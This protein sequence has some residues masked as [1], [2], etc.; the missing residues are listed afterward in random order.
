MAKNVNE[1]REYALVLRQGEALVGHISFGPWFGQKTYELGWA[2]APPHQCRGYA[3]EAARA[4]LSH[5]FG[6]ARIHR[7]IA[8]CNPDNT[9]SVRVMEKLG[10]RREAHFRKGHEQPDG[11]WTDEY[12]YALLESEWPPT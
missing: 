8:T 9:A 6:T 7:V 2:V 5:A 10:M 3:T 4:V 11:S 12:F 1:P